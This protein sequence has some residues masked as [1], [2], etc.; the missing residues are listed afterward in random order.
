[1]PEWIAEKFAAIVEFVRN[2]RVEF[3]LSPLETMK[4]FYGQEYV[5]EKIAEFETI[6][7][8]LERNE[9]QK[10]EEKEEKKKVEEEEEEELQWTLH[11]IRL[12]ARQVRELKQQLQ[13]VFFD[14]WVFVNC[15]Q[16]EEPHFESADFN[17]NNNNGKNMTTTTTTTTTGFEQVVEV[18]PEL[19]LADLLS[20]AR[21]QEITGE[22][23]LPSTSS[24]LRYRTIEQQQQPEKRDE[25][26]KS[27][28]IT[29][30]RFEY[31]QREIERQIERQIEREIE[32]QIERHLEQK[33]ESEYYLTMAIQEQQP[34]REQQPR[35]ANIDSVIEE[36]EGELVKLRVQKEFSPLLPTYPTSFGGQQQK[37]QKTTTT[38]TRVVLGAGPESVRDE[39][40]GKIVG[41]N[42]LTTVVPA[43]FK[44]ASKKTAFYPGTY[45]NNVVVEQQQRM[46]FGGTHYRFKVQP[47]QPFR[48]TIQKF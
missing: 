35:L 18:L 7:G 46:P 29:T 10:Q 3:S 20:G 41:Q 25:K 34:K 5:R 13:Q 6:L 31:Q 38:T 48:E 39:I 14:E 16:N 26:M 30:G 27:T 28:E 43:I 45:G 37:E 21:Q 24:S 23:V 8:F 19:T 40:F 33:D 4:P 12:T 44:E 15:Q 17:N 2:A 22:F 47:Q 42:L 9:E 11:Y 32:R 1:M 36:L